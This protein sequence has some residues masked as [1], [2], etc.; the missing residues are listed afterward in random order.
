MK[1]LVIP[2]VTYLDSQTAVAFK[3]DGYSIFKGT[4]SPKEKVKET[5]EE[6]I[7][8]IFHK[9]EKIFWFC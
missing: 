9:N 4:E 5:I 3:D 1:T 2:Q 8:S 7:V 6:E